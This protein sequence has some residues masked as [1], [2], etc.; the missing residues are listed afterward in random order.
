MFLEDFSF[1][2]FSVLYALCFLTANF[3][4]E[5]SSGFVLVGSNFSVPVNESKRDFGYPLFFNITRQTQ[6]PRVGKGTCF[7]RRLML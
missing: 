3:L 5:L 1:L 7:V 6:K 2:S 4:L